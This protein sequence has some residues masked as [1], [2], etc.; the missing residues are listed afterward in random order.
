LTGSDPSPD[1]ASP[2]AMP[3]AGE[4]ASTARKTIVLALQRGGIADSNYEAR[5][6]IEDLAGG[7]KLDATAAWRLGA[8]L[9]RRLAGEPLWR[10]LGAREFWGLSFVLSPGTLEPRPDSESLIGAALAHLDSRRQEPL[11]MLDL[12]TGTGCLLIA[13]LCEFPHATGIGVDLSEDAV[14]T[15]AG[16]A[17]R[18]GVAARAQFR[19][20]RWDD[21]L[22]GRFDLILSNPPY[23][24][25]DE[26]SRL[27]AAVREHDPH[28]ALDGGPDGLAAY[29]E[30]ARLLP[31]RL[32]P[33]GRI[34]LEIGAGQEAEVTAL[35][36]AARL[37]HLGSQRD[38][39]GHERAL[40][41]AGET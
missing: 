25:S 5:I 8:A 26:I 20:A 9:A 21:G 24:A 35:M 19:Q 34:V 14:A 31:G 33:G 28:L 18:N 11:R 1:T 41:F 29:R 38:L 23:I 10:I 22:S 2:V 16:N 4:S 3:A 13:A 12:G 7:E 36:S 30:L 39:G 15:A 27:D 37:R 40:V 6:L 17:G 32:A